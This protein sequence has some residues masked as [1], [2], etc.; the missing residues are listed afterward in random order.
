MCKGDKQPLRDLIHPWMDEGPNWINYHTEMDAKPDKRL[1]KYLPKAKKA[2]EISSTL[3]FKWTEISKVIQEKLEAAD[4]P[5]HYTR[6]KGRN[7]I[8]YNIKRS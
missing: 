2:Q 1:T 4:Y 5:N 7:G 6:K 3:V 8:P